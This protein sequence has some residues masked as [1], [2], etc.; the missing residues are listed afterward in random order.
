MC[1]SRDMVT[2]GGVVVLQESEAS[3][4]MLR[5][6]CLRSGVLVPPELMQSSSSLANSV[7]LQVGCCTCTLCCLTVMERVF[8]I[9]CKFNYSSTLQVLLVS[10]FSISTHHLLT[11]L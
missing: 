2:Y 7:S 4:R 6:L 8:S 5:E 11:P 3:C 9:R 10:A 1:C